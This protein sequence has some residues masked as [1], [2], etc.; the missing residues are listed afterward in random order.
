VHRTWKLWACLALTLSSVPAA[1]AQIV[2]C[3]DP[4][5]GGTDPG[6]QGCGLSEAAINLSV[7][8]AL[9]DLLVADPALKP[10]M[11]RT[12]DVFI[13][14]GG[15][16]AYANDNGAV[17]FASIH[18]NSATAASATGIETYSATSSS[19]KSIDQRDRI[20]DAMTAAW[21]LADRGGK[22]AGFYVIVNTNMPATLSEL[23]F[24]TNCGKDATYLGSA[25]KQQLAAQAHL[26]A[27]RAS[28]GLAP[29]DVPD[30]LP[31]TGSLRGVVYEDQGV[32]SADLSVRLPGAKVVATCEG[33]G[34]ATVTAESPDGAWFFESPS[35]DC[36]VTASLAGYVTASR[37]CTVAAGA[38]AWC[39]VGLVEKAVAVPDP[40]PVPDALAM[41]DLAPTPDAQADA[42]SP[43]VGSPDVAPAEDSSGLPD[44]VGVA[45][46]VGPFDVAPDL[47]VDTAPRRPGV[48][49]FSDATLVSQTPDAAAITGDGCQAARG[50]DGALW[51]LGLLALLLTRRRRAALAVASLALAGA[52][53]PAGGDASTSRAA[54]ESAQP[55]APLLAQIARESPDTLAL[56]SP[57][58]IT[59]S[60]DAS[61]PIWS[62]DGAT[63]AFTNPSMDRLSVVSAQGGLP[64]LLVSAP[65][66]GYAPVWQSATVLGHRV[67]GQR[68][69]DI[70]MTALDLE[71]RL[72]HAPQNPTPNRW[73]LV[74]DD[75]VW[76][77]VGRAETRISPDGDR[78]CCAVTT[79]D[80]R[81]T[82][83]LGLAEGLTV[84]DAQ[85]HTRTTF[86]Q[87]RSPAFSA[88]GRHLAFVR[89]TDD[90]EQILTRTLHLA[91]L[92]T[93]PPTV[94]T[95]VG[96]SLFADHPALSPDGR[97]LAYD[98][99]GSLWT[100]ALTE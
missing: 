98:A 46:V 17:R 99:D 11:T 55:S 44:A 94:K 33:V 54:L 57:Q 15:R 52:C 18:S 83:F 29:G 90:G 8:L 60:I 62:P 36:T 100:A 72:Q 23:G 48:F 93:A 19:A 10:I 64:R 21:P 73:T 20:Q 41:P 34:A 71:G 74:R 86:G 6:A 69:S 1:S 9:R 88:D 70:P 3:V 59:D 28:L 38:T 43:D 31:S 50:A 42:G 51:L 67:A 49:S 84:Y 68:S 87:A 13:S 97:T 65:A 79:P 4:G 32:G 7:S 92:T 39:S 56:G 96:A 53:G 77:R 24:I 12:T 27:L 35:G 76:L 25:A 14:L 40:D 26:D 95:L 37:T 2:I 82:A 30:P 89:E 61:A 85:T 47:A 78:H 75:A 66:A 16:A 91:D 5:H 45:D 80:G 58:R 81:Y 22:T 63:L